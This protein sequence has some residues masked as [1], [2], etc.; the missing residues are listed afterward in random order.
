MGAAFPEHPGGIGF[1][2]VGL[3]FPKDR[4]SESFSGSL[5]SVAQHRHRGLGCFQSGNLPI[6]NHP[7]PCPGKVSEGSLKCTSQTFPWGMFQENSWLWLG[8]ALAWFMELELPY[9]EIQGMLGWVDDP[10]SPF[11]ARTDEGEELGSGREIGK[12]CWGQ[13]CLGFRNP[14]HLGIPSPAEG[15]G[16]TQGWH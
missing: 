5:R 11:P 16:T 7:P 8:E 12:G 1:I 4:N 13:L 15:F 14:S 10:A 6:H 9:M 3:A 2:P